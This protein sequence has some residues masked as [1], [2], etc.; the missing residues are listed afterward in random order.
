MARTF[1]SNRS[2]TACLL[3]DCSIA[4]YVDG[5][6]IAIVDPNLTIDEMRA[7]IT[8]ACRMH[9]AKLAIIT[10]RISNAKLIDKADQQM[11]NCLDAAAEIWHK[12]FAP[13]L[14]KYCDLSTINS[15]IGWKVLGY[16][17]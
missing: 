2:V 7:E 13:M 6:T 1:Y 12:G 4:V 8:Q 17:K 10:A 16:L 11:N 3:N 15:S 14:R 9:A 5:K